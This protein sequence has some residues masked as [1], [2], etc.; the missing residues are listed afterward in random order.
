[1]LATYSAS[2]RIKSGFTAL[3]LGLLTAFFVHSTHAEESKVDQKCIELLT[4][5]LRMGVPSMLEATPSVDDQY[6]KRLA[7]AVDQLGPDVFNRFVG[8]LTSERLREMRALARS[9]EL[10]DGV[11]A[12]FLTYP[13]FR[14]FIVDLADLDFDTSG[15]LFGSTKMPSVVVKELLAARGFDPTDRE[16][17]LDRDAVRIRKGLNASL[18]AIVNRALGEYK[19]QPYQ[20]GLGQ[21][22][23]D[24]LH[25]FIFPLHNRVLT[26][27][28]HGRNQ[29]DRMELI[30]V[31]DEIIAAKGTRR[32]EAIDLT[33]QEVSELRPFLN[34]SAEQVKGIHNEVVRVYGPLVA[35]GIALKEKDVHLR[36]LYSS[37][38]SFDIRAKY[39]EAR[40]DV[41]QALDALDH[42]LD[43]A[44]QRRGQPGR[45]MS[46][47]GQDELTLRFDE[48][49]ERSDQ[50]K[51]KYLGITGESSRMW[52]TV[53]DRR[54]RQVLVGRDKEGKPIYETEVYY[55]NRTVYP[56]Y[57]NILS[58]SFDRGDR[59]V[60]GLDSVR[61]ATT[62][63]RREEG[64]YRS[65]IGLVEQLVNELSTEFEKFGIEK[66]AET[67]ERVARLQ[68]RLEEDLERLRMYVSWPTSQIHVQWGHDDAGNFKRRNRTML[69][70]LQNGA[71]SLAYS[72]EILKREMPSAKFRVKRENFTEAMNLLRHKMWMNYAIKFT[73]VSAISGGGYLIHENPHAPEQ[74]WNWMQFQ[75]QSALQVLAPHFDRLGQF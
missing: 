29:N 66:R 59:F 63:V 60:S 55:V 47:R 50:L 36:A 6:Q 46:D 33:S 10:D 75:M 8:Q 48:K 12:V 32:K 14:Q 11:S 57:E 51:T 28:N 24:R 30:S 22:A 42:V 38:K 20:R 35:N 56:S 71:S 39:A 62:G 64:R 44:F 43:G 23:L 72:L 67:V 70:R 40:A 1:M 73:G 52:Y 18:A 17:I 58:D 31:V 13:S 69:H 2:I 54:T 49:S 26:L 15:A 25:R 21:R 68:G 74:A 19:G 7:A 9:P 3:I 45:P 34:D 27:L 4:G 53:E 16:D 41:A 37:A 65:T 61:Y 5:A